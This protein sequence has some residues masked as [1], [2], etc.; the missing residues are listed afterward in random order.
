MKQWVLLRV[1]LLAAV[2]LLVNALAFAQPAARVVASDEAHA[3]A[4]EA[5]LYFYPLVTMDVTRRQLTNV[6]GGTDIRGPHNMFHH[7]PVYPPASFRGVVRP[8]FDTLYS[9]AWL[10]L[11][12]EPVIVSAPNT[13]GRNFMLP[14]ID[15]WTDVIAC[16][17]SRTTGNEA[18]HFLVAL[19]SGRGRCHPASSVSTHRLRTCGFWAARG[20]TARR[21]IRPSITSR[22][23]T[24]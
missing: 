19:P 2:L 14:M 18:G 6:E 11:T 4:L 21:S 9:F 22:R 10:D 20:P 12:T 24:R 16:P 1:T 13:G 3:I 17:G 5:Y 15:M 8:N 23:A 7:A